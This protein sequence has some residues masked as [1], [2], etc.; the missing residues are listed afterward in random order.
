MYVVHKRRPWAI[1]KQLTDYHWTV[2][3]LLNINYK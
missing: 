1:Y 2:I 3:F